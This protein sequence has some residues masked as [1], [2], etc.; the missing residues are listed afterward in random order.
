VDFIAKKIFS[1]SMKVHNFWSL[2]TG[3]GGIKLGAVVYIRFVIMLEI[4]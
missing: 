2:F 3:F 4:I 1:I